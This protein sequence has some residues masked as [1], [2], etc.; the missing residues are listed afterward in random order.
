MLEKLHVQGQITLSLI[1]MFPGKLAA[2]AGGYIT[3]ISH[4]N[5]K[6]Y[7]STALLLMPQFLHPR[8]SHYKETDLGNISDTS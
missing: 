2:P 6:T 7:I 1:R 5:S 8:I 3:C 4:E